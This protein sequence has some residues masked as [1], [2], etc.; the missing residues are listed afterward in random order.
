MKSKSEAGNSK[1]E[2]YKAFVV[3][4]EAANPNEANNK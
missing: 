2:G 3:K 1:S 4:C